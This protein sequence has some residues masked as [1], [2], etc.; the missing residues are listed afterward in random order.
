MAKFECEWIGARLPLWVDNGECNMASDL[1]GERGDLTA[2]ERQEIS[3]H[4]AGCAEC[5]GHRIALEQ[6]LGMLAIAANQ[7]PV[8]SGAPSLWPLLE[9]RI[10]NHK[11]PGRENRPLLPGSSSDRLTGPWADLDGTR[12]LRRAWTR[13]TISELLSD[14][15]HR[16]AQSGRFLS[17][18]SRA[19]LAAT[20]LVMVTV[21]FLT[22][23][24]WTRAQSTILAN[25]I[26][27]ADPVP[28]PT[29][30]KESL[31]E[32]IDRDRNDVPANE[33]ADAQ[34]PGPAETNPSAVEALPPKPSSRTR[35]GFD[36]EHGIP[37]P[38]DTRDTKPVY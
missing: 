29:V 31:P 27:L 18:F 2:E 17:L 21:V 38:P 11:G 35:F 15:K 36:L 3:Q 16:N 26:P 8:V 7:F 37:M 10:A 23:R 1:R 6:A 20:V 24:Q 19:G 13:D 14:G 22:H 5:S 9:Q 34:L 4:L 28:V 25:T 33:L 12:P 32:I 30:T